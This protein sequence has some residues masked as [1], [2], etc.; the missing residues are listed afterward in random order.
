MHKWLEGCV[1]EEVEVVNEFK[2]VLRVSKSSW[3]EDKYFQV[4]LNDENALEYHRGE[5]PSVVWEE[6]DE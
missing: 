6:I 5:I 3:V 4:R 2:L 1:I